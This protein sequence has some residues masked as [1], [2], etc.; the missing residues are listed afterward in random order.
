MIKSRFLIIAILFTI[1]FTSCKKETDEPDPVIDSKYSSGVFIINEGNF[2]HGNGSISYLETYTNTISHNIFETENDR[3]LGDVVQSMTMINEKAFICVN[4]SNKIE[5][6]YSSTF[7]ELGVINDVPLV[8]NIIKGNNG[9]A[10]ASSWGN[11][12]QVFV[13]NPETLKVV[14]TIP[15]GLGP[16]GML[17][18]DNLLY[19]ANSGGLTVDETISVINTNTNELIE[20]I[21]LGSYSPRNFV[22]DH[23]NNIWVICS[24]TGSW[25]TVGQTA[26][27]LHKIDEDN[28]TSSLSIKLFDEIQPTHLEIDPTGTVLV[29]GGGFGTSGL[30]KINLFE[31]HPVNI[32]QFI[33][34]TFYGFSIDPETS[35]IYTANAGDYSN[36]GIIN[37]YNFMGDSLGEYEAAIIPNGVTF[38]EDYYIIN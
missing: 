35:T 21:N 25:S 36:N 11:D 3:N 19:V 6:V 8:R 22:I 20:T 5:V 18:K 28:L 32:E 16:E 14:A 34:G 9:M 38:H 29:F 23:E 24:G 4:N 30:Y 31:T 7:K 33:D 27:W 37:L 13:I 10:Y 26:S 17:I 12:G 1:V 15:V 2:G